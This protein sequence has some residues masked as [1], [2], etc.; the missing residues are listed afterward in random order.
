[1]PR[2]VPLS[3]CR[4]IGIVAHIDAG[5]TT[6]SERIL[7]YTGRSFR[8]GEVDDGTATLDWMEQER[9]RGIT[10]AA[11][12]T[13]CFWRDHRITLIDTPGHVDFGIEVERSLRVL[14]GAVAVFDAVAGVEPQTEAVWR[15]ADAFHVPRL[16]FVNKMDRPGA[17]FARTVRMIQDRL[18]ARAVPLQLP[19]GAEDGFEGVVD[20]INERALIWASEEPGRPH[21]VRPI[22]PSLWS[23]AEEARE[24]LIEVAAETDERVLEAWINGDAPDAAQ[25]RACLRK[26]VIGGAFVPVLCGAARRNKGIE[27]L[28]DAV[29]DLLPSPADVAGPRPAADDQPFL[30]LAFK[31]SGD[32]TFAR[33]Y[34]GCLAAGAPVWNAS[35][36]VE[37]WPSGLLAVHAD[38]TDA[39]GEARTGDILAFKGLSATH[40][41][42]TLTDPAH[43][44]I[45]EALSCP[46]A[47]IEIAVE[48]R[49][50]EDR[51]R[52]LAA[53]TTLCGADPSLR[54]GR[55]PETGQTVLAG[56]GELHLDVTIERLRQEYGLTLTAGAPRVAWRESAAHPGEAER[57]FQLGDQS[58]WIRLRVTPGASGS[59]LV[60]GKAPAGAEAGV[61]AAASSGPLGGS[62]VSDLAVE[63][64]AADEGASAHVMELAARSAFSAALAEAGPVLLEPV[65]RIEI[66]VPDEHLG[67]VLGDLAARRGTVDGVDAR[68]EDRVVSAK[69]PLAGL[70]G[71]VGAL[72][73][74]SRG[75]ARMSMHFDRYARR[76]VPL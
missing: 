12:A 38:E 48:P 22:P 42:D 50:E 4:N 24:R 8:M 53:L 46:E 73:S 74:L 44:M 9:E 16:C 29:V 19:I 3:L 23:A 61:R 28:L 63:V 10:I 37:E 72:R 32:L 55:D 57:G 67:A 17:D 75:R 35:R 15:Q 26:A 68:G 39:V 25:L 1:M 49:I 5:K 70:F 71:Y 51:P 54:L 31:Q 41:G 6:T 7:F 58:A 21:A 11:A 56:M 2:V 52:L 59:G 27:P 36:G 69:A 14:D 43:P 66:L 60:I 40:G 76:D 20:L 18:G 34:S 45:L 64:M 33:V 47:V 30:A 65:M 62:P 13:T